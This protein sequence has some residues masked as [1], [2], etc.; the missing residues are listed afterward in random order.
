MLGICSFQVLLLLKAHIVE[1]IEGV[2]CFSMILDFLT[3]YAGTT[4]FSWVAAGSYKA[5]HSCSTS[6]IVIIHS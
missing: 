4:W 3:E 2:S 1:V 5:A 6:Y